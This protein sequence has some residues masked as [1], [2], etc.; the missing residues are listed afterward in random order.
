MLWRLV[1][2]QSHTRSACASGLRRTRRPPAARKA[3]GAERNPG[4]ASSVELRSAGYPPSKR[5]TAGVSQ[6]RARKCA[7][8][9]YSVQVYGLGF[10]GHVRSTRVRRFFAFQ[11]CRVAHLKSCYNPL[12]SLRGGYIDKACSY[13]YHVRT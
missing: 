6:A 7:S 5:A 12:I 10:R 9:R 8:A 11:P 1:R 3:R 2:Y 13:Y 4:M